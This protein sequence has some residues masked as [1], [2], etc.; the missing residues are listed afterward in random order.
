MAELPQYCHAVRARQ[1][2]VQQY[3]VIALNAEQLDR[4]DSVIAIIHTVIK[5]AQAADDRLA[6]R[7]LVF[8]N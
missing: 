7:L 2:Q 4:L 3:K 5:T 1:I 6:K 8:N